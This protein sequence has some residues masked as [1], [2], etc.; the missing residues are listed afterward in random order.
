MICKMGMRTVTLTVALLTQLILLWPYK[1][2]RK[3]EYQVTR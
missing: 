2:Q 3:I 1:H